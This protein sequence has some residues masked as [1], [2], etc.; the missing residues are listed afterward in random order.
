MM[1]K[2]Q[3]PAAS[4]VN[5]ETARLVNEYVPL[6]R[7][8]VP[9]GNASR[10]TLLWVSVPR[11]T[12]RQVWLPEM[13]RRTAAASP[14][15]ATVIVSQALPLSTKARFGVAEPDQL[16]GFGLLQLPVIVTE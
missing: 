1:H 2:V 6:L 16:P 10:V 4:P 11:K 9:I 3:V 13:S 14:D 12:A 15:E 8:N 7:G 5:P